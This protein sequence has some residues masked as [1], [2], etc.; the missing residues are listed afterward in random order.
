MIRNDIVFLNIAKRFGFKHGKDGVF[1]AVNGQPIYLK[2]LQHPRS[3]SLVFTLNELTA[4]RVTKDIIKKFSSEI[5]RSGQVKIEN[6]VLIINNILG[7]FSDSKLID[8][9]EKIIKWWSARLK[10][11]KNFEISDSSE[12][13][14]YNKIPGPNNNDYK[15][16]IENK[17]RKE[18]SRNPVNNYAGLFNGGI[19]AFIASVFVGLLMGIINHKFKFSF[20][21]IDLTL[22]LGIST[23]VYKKFSNGFNKQSWKYILPVFLVCVIASQIA[24]ITTIVWSKDGSFDI[25]HSLETFM[26]QFKVWNKY[27]GIVLIIVF[28]FMYLIFI[29]D[30]KSETLEV[31]E[32]VYFTS[33]DEDF[34]K[35]ENTSSSLVG[36]YI[37]FG[38]SISITSI[39]LY[40]LTVLHDVSFVK[41]WGYLILIILVYPVSFFVFIKIYKNKISLSPFEK[42]EKQS[43]VSFIGGHILVHLST[44][45]V[46]FAMTNFLI[47]ANVYLDP[48]DKKEVHGILLEDY[49]EDL[50]RCKELKVL[51]PLDGEILLEFCKANHEIPKSGNP[52][53]LNKGIGLLGI[54]YY[55]RQ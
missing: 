42:S 45:F 11:L 12:V 20:P 29:M 36:K 33:E 6:D 26:N 34:I 27:A 40:A 9:L 5:K 1:G 16:T 24:H 52:V 3:F 49:P 25:G 44:L 55:E 8:R 32:G 30:K 2:N 17:L 14:L 41:L 7:G 10:E 48:W 38:M 46:A 47:M 53:L 28:Q 21:V 13:V 22:V 35:I 4:S 31:E 18:L 39:L 54:N 19:L 43:M 15:N 37:V 23:R 51:T 50:D